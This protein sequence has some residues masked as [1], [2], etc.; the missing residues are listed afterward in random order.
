MS[1]GDNDIENEVLILSC[2]G[3]DK[4]N[5]TSLVNPGPMITD[6]KDSRAIGI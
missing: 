1:Y 5:K 6:H 3:G 2:F 4:K